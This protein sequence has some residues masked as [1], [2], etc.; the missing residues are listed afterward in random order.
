MT[1]FT[2]HLN[3][4]H[5]QLQSFTTYADKTAQKKTATID[6][7]SVTP[8]GTVPT[9]VDCSDETKPSLP[10][11]DAATHEQE[12]KESSKTLKKQDSQSSDDTETCCCKRSCCS[13]RRHNRSRH[14]GDDIIVED[15]SASQ[16][17]DTPFSVYDAFYQIP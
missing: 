5:D 10:K 12:E 13:S 3:D 2:S 7:P 17:F 16:N 15:A 6:Q 4:I 11:D 8:P 1:Q 14:F 9:T